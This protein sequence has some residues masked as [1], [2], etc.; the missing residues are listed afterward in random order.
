MEGFCDG[1]V[2]GLVD[3]MR[4]GIWFRGCSSAE[5]FPTGLLPYGLAEY[6]DPPIKHQV[7]E[8][9]P[10]Q[11]SVILCKTPATLECACSLEIY[12]DLINNSGCPRRAQIL[13]PPY[14]P[15]LD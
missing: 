11:T 1:S 8:R 14:Q 7:F 4:R 10:F 9:L 12:H 2:E 6:D 3:F 15:H 5:V 13:I